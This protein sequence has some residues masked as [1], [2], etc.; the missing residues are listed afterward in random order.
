MKSARFVKVAFLIVLTGAFLGC[1]S[2]EKA[3]A[4][5]GPAA[6]KAPLAASVPD[7]VVPE[8]DKTDAKAEA[9]RVMTQL[10]GD[11]FAAMYKEAAPAFRE[12]GTEPQFVAMM[13]QTR[14]KTGAM[15]SFKEV[16]LETGPDQRQMVNYSVDYD[17]VK[18]K[19]RLSFLRS[20]SGKMELVGL[21]QKDD[22]VKNKA[23]VKK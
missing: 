13:Q 14:Q 7:A 22:L 9:A 21:N 16:G 19:L 18:S 6:E 10:K 3:A 12:L 4:P 8:K 15:Q 17:N 11:D 1:D 2:K 5:A 20:K 23:A